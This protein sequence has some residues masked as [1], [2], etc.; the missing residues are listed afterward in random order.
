MCVCRCVGAGVCVCMCYVLCCMRICE[1]GVVVQNNVPFTLVEKVIL[2]QTL[3][4]NINNLDVFLYHICNNKS[5]VFLCSSPMY[6]IQCQHGK[7]TTI[8]K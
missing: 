1:A 5:K 4:I 6:T 8:K 3:I 7:R 2:I